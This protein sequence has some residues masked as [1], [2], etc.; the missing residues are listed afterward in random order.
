MK[1]TTKKTA[2]KGKTSPKVR[3]LSVRKENTIKGG[4]I[5]RTGGSAAPSITGAWISS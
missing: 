1:K 3:D 5:R 2:S 4:V